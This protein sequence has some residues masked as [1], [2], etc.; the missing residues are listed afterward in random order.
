M[1]VFV[2]DG[3]NRAALA[4]TRSLGRAGHAVIVGDAADV[5][6]AQASRYCSRRVR[7]PNPSRESD[8]FVERVAAIVRELEVEAVVPIAD[9]TTFLLAGHRGCFPESCLIPT[10][11][12]DVVMRAA[13]KVEILRTA[14]RIGVAVPRGVVVE[15]PRPVPDL[16]FGFPVVV[17]PGRSRVRTKDGWRST[18]VRYA[19]DRQELAAILAS[20]P[21]HEFP[22]LLQER[23]RGDGM[24]VFA[25][26]QEGRPV[27]LFSHRRLRERPPWGGVSVLC[28]SV[29]VPK[30]AGEFAMRLLTE[31]GWRGV[32]MVEFKQDARDGVPRLMEINGRFWGSLQLAVD[33]GVDFPNL[34]LASAKGCPLPPQ[35]PYRLGVRDRWLWG[36]VDSLLV[37]LFGGD[38]APHLA[39][40]SR[41]GALADFAKV[42]SPRLYYDNPKWDDPWPWAVESY[43]WFR[44]MFRNAAPLRTLI[45]HQA[46]PAAHPTVAVAGTSG[47]FAPGGTHQTSGI[48]VDL[49][50][51]FEELALPA[52]DWNALAASGHTNSVFQT[53]EW[54]SGW[55]AA[56]QDGYQQFLLRATHPDGSQ[57]IAP[58]VMETGRFGQRI[59]RF[60]GDGR[61]DYCDCLAP[62][63]RA[64][65]L[66]SLWRKA[67]GSS[68]WDVIDL[69]NVPATSQTIET[70]RVLGREA[71]FCVEIDEGSVCPT[72]LIRG[73]EDSAR[74]ILNKASLRRRLNYFER[75]G[76]LACRD[77]RRAGEIRPLLEAFFAQHIARWSGTRSPSLFV[78][79]RNRLFYRKLTEHLDSTGWL[80]FSVIEFDGRPIAFH[81]GF[82]YEGTVTWYKPSFD[83]A[84][85]A[86]SPGLVLVKHLIGYAVDCGRHEL[87]FTVG[88]EPFKERFTNSASMTVRVQVFRDRARWALERMG[89]RV[90]TVARHLSHA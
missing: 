48:A 58:L 31:I 46:R 5:S 25:C 19:A 84:F 43:D 50:R 56:Y 32:A 44:G 64:D 16:D 1:K 38:G 89:K 71:G 60:A 73:Y 10:A 6:L 52:A 17:K 13:D 28:E 69:N 70:V 42:W 20:R 14:A 66:E 11:D 85:A 33:A 9:I 80:L 75:T 41:L 87:D 76:N 22:L 63:G 53:Y 29:P 79:P 37:T 15:Q 59:M 72:L 68:E 74:R 3:S 54:T 55:W 36:D 88:D 57:A 2:T 49:H 45:R 62:S 27:A 83:P 77:F 78:K 40:G 30:I 61:A 51:S 8:A 67:L 90:R 81:Y 65:L 35:A 4:V 7:Y 26:Y 23:I 82:D 34:L 18:S 47:D 24:G 21:E 86:R 12:I 39:R